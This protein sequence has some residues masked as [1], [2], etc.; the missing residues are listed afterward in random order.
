MPPTG[1]PFPGRRVFPAQGSQGTVWDLGPVCDA[2][3]IDGSA[4]YP[5]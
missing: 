1:N 5:A 2:G 3:R 4:F